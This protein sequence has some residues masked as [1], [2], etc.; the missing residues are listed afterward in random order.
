MSIDP[1]PLTELVR[2]LF[3]EALADQDAQRQQLPDRLAFSEAEI[4]RLLS[5]H[6]HQLRD[7]RRRRRS[8]ASQVVGKRIRYTREDLMSYFA[9]NRI[10]RGE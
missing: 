10:E 1:G 6:Q 7:E 8:A 4:S 2:R 9:A 3:A 5:L